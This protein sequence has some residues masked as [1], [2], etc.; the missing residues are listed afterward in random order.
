MESQEYMVPGDSVI[1]ADEANVMGESTCTDCEHT[2]SN[3]HGRNIWHGSVLILTSLQAC[4]EG[5]VET[6]DLSRSRF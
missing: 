6:Q 4:S 1:C 5:C 2:E 3:N